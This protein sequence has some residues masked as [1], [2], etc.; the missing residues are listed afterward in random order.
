M[1][2]LFDGAQSRRGGPL[3]SDEVA[4]G[5][6]D[7]VGHEGDPCGAVLRPLQDQRLGLGA[8]FA[9]EPAVS[10]SSRRRG[11]RRL[12]PGGPV[13]QRHT[14]AGGWRRSHDPSRVGR[15]GDRSLSDLL[16]RL[17]LA[18]S[19]HCREGATY[20]RRRRGLAFP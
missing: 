16:G 1:C 9:C 12:I 2:G 10:T 15:W 7:D 18:P 5:S 17:S 6:G 14:S 3:L 11:G 19:G 20:V 8:V 4:A 13:F